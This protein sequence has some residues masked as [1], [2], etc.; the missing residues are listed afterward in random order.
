MSFSI[1]PKAA[2]SLASENNAQSSQSAQSAKERAIAKLLGN[3]PQAQPT[4]PQNNVTPENLSAISPKEPEPSG[5]TPTVEAPSDKASVSEKGTEE[6]LSPQYAVLARKEKALRA[7]A[8]A[9][10]Q[11]FKAKE[12][13]LVAREEAL[14]AKEAEYQSNYIS[15]DKLK[16]DAWSV[17][18]ELGYSY[19]QL[20]Q[21]A[22]NQSQ[23][24][25][26]QR[27]A[28]QRLEAKIQQLE[29][30]NK[31]SQTTAQEQQ[32]KAY[33]QAVEQIRRDTTALVESDPTTY[34]AIHKSGS[35][36]EVV[37]LIEQTFKEDGVLMTVEEAAQEIENYLVEE[38]LKYA[39]FEKVKKRLQPATPPAAEQK[40]ETTQ[41]QPTKTLTNGMGASRQLSA[42][43]RALLAFKGEL[44]N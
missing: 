41:S 10:E 42:R 36:D 4:V 8:Q 28:I 43:E 12:E 9:Q 22:L 3:A 24:S 44:K 27:A 40:A 26:A 15:K 21:E 37:A 31:K 35:I 38:S 18:N 11:A 13:A 30:E 2:P 25:P 34:E 20:T 19:E 7:K 33:K 23:E 29:A 14:K 16:T 5:Q 17:L 39:Q 6:P 32:T 1:A